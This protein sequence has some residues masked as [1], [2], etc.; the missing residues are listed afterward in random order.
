MSKLPEMNHKEIVMRLVGNVDP[1]GETSIDD[2][3]FQNLIVLCDLAEELVG[4]ID[5]VSR[6]NKDRFEYSMKRAG[7]YAHKFLAG[8]LGIQ[9]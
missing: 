6:F 3:N 7:Q 2:R 1:I 9:E 4:V 8:R 5:D